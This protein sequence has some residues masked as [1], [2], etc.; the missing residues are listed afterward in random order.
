[1]NV[2]QQLDPIFKPRSIAV[3]GASDIPERWGYRMLSNSLS[4]GFRGPIYP[5]HPSAKVMLGLKVY[6]SVLAIPGPVDLAVIVVPAAVVPQVV[7]ECVQKGVKGA[8][9]ITAGFAEVGPQGKAAQDAIIDAA[10]RGGLRLLGPNCLGIFSAAASLNLCFKDAPEPGHIAFISQSGTFGGYLAETAVAKGYGLSAFVSIGNQADLTATDFLEYLKEDGNTKAVAL[11]L[12][13]VKDGRR[14]MEVARQ[15][16]KRKPVLLYKAGRTEAGARATRSH[17]GALAGQD[18]VFDA[19][20]RQAG[21]M[22]A[23]EVLE[24][25][26]MAQALVHQPLPRGRRIAILGSGGLGVVTS[27]ACCRLGLEVPEFDSATQS[28]LK[29]HVSPHA[30]TPR[31]PF[32]FAGGGRTASAEAEVVEEIARLPY[33]DGI[34]MPSPMRILA[35]TVAEE[36]QDTAAACERVAAIPG[37]HGKPLILMNWSARRKGIGA[38]VSISIL[39]AAGIPLYDTPEQCAHA[40]YSLARYAEIK[41]EL[42]TH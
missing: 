20:C 28:E 24:V 37:K 30:P 18:T 27:D 10:R 1:M 21:I 14:F 33:I 7:A 3:I 9:L 16:V 31:N 38:D 6:P 29:K 13:G 22:R 2:T 17:T 41:R 8:V 34:I 12:E 19:M 4:S 15:T 40:M 42:N 5:V 32:D 35:G 36:V 11:Y 26:D 25:F 39:T 23:E